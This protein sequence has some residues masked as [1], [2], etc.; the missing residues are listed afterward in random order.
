MMASPESS[1]VVTSQG[2]DIVATFTTNGLCVAEASFGGLSLEQVGKAMENGRA[3]I[4]AVRSIFRALLLPDAPEMTEVGAGRILSEIGLER[5]AEVIQAAHGVWMAGAVAEPITIPDADQQG[6]LAF[7]AG[8]VRFVLAFHFNAMAEIEPVFPGLSMTMIAAELLDGGTSVVR[9]RAM[10]RAALIDDREVS[11]FEAGE[12]IDRIGMAVVSKAVGKAF[13]SAFPKIPDDVEPEAED[14][15][16]RKTR[17]AAAA[18][19][20]NPT[21]PRRRKAGTGKA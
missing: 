20:A 12:L 18:G 1:R 8:G 13:V 6:R 10:F 5:A 7:E 19:K 3:S 21:K 2:R 9:L 11:L 4:A 17:R 16:N 15:G 14:D